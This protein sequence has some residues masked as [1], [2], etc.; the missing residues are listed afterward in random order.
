MDTALDV[1]CWRF[2]Y[3]VIPNFLLNLAVL[4]FVV[5]LSLI[6]VILECG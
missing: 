3:G 1:L 6:R 5:L 2:R 4:G